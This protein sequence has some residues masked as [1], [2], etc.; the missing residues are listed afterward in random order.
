MGEARLLQDAPPALIPQESLAAAHV[1]DVLRPYT[2]RQV[3][4]GTVER[5]H[6]AVEGAIALV[7]PAHRATRHV[8]LACSRC[9]A[10]GVGD[11]AVRIALKFCWDGHM[12]QPSVGGVASEV[13]LAVDVVCGIVCRVG[14][15]RWR[16]V[17]RSLSSWWSTTLA[18][19]MF[20]SPTQAARSAVCR[21][22]AG[23][24]GPSR[25]SVCDVNHSGAF[26]QSLPT[27]GVL[28]LSLILSVSLP[29]VSLPSVF[30]SISV[31]EFHA[32]TCTPSVRL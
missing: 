6:V 9:G 11:S 14:E 25:T 2:V 8:W 32:Q 17:A 31:A 1:L 28:C 16:T 18:A 24:G 30:T 29:S 15:H 13:V 3:P 4:M 21:S 10:A 19:A 20:S 7:A 26:C 5:V 22:L 23:A 12:A 27:P